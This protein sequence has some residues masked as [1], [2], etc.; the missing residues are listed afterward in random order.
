MSHPRLPGGGRRPR[1]RRWVLPL[2]LVV[3]VAVPLAEVW[4]LLQVGNWIGLIPTVGLLVGLAI[5]GTWLSRHQGSRAWKGLNE[6]TST[7]RLPTGEL[8]DAALILVGAL[9]LVFPGFFTDIVG[10]VFLL[11]FTRPLA[12][13]L[14]GWAIAGQAK[15]FAPGPGVLPPFAPFGP[16]AGQQPRTPPRYGNG[17]VIDG[18]VV[19]DESA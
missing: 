9:L 5:L 15:K 16:P 1:G 6:A 18:E 2:L 7:G 10:L 3:L 13:R 8:A 11:P 4:L 14:F 19:D 17:E 12:K